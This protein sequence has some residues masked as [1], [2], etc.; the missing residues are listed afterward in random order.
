MDS[1]ATSPQNLYRR[2]D[3]VGF[4]RKHRLNEALQRA[5]SGAG[6]TRAAVGAVSILPSLGAVMRKGF[7]WLAAAI[8][9]ASFSPLLHATVIDFNDPDLVGAYFDGDTFTQNGFL[10]TQ[11]F[12]PGTVDFAA[13]LGAVA[14]TGNATQFY[15]NSNAGELAIESLNG[16]PF[17]L[18]GFSAAFVPG[19]TAPVNPIAI[20]AFGTTKTGALVGVAFSFGDTSTTGHGYPFQTFSGAAFANFK[21]LAMVEFFACGVIA[22]SCSGDPL[23]LGQF[24]LDDVRVTAAVPEPETYAL[25]VAGLLAIGAVRRRR[26]R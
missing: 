26:A 21:N 5:N 4:C 7:R 16:Q 13:A 17:S 6:P 10:M 22:G 8:V 20:A 23:D 14:P 3:I 12:D 19:A 25:M 24:A 9:A 2:C 18:D 11:G 1:S 15:F